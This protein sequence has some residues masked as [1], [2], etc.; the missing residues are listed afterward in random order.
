MLA[1]KGLGGEDWNT[2]VEGC[3]QSIQEHTSEPGTRVA[4]MNELLDNGIMHVF[5]GKS[6]HF[7]FDMFCESTMCCQCTDALHKLNLVLNEVL[8]QHTRPISDLVWTLLSI[9]DDIAATV[10]SSEIDFHTM[11]MLL[12]YVLHH[13]LA[14]NFKA[15]LGR[16]YTHHMR[17]RCM[18]IGCR[19]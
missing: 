11:G 19:V 6:A 16:S 13:R 17:H 12:S 10:A 4:V 5:R 1:T 14:P 18:E 15:S 8:D 7:R 2:R 3:L 9:T